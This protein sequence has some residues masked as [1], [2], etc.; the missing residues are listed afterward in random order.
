MFSAFGALVCGCRSLARKK[1]EE[2]SLLGAR[3]GLNPAIQQ[4]FNS[5]PLPAVSDSIHPKKR[6]KKKSGGG[7]EGGGGVEGRISLTLLN[8]AVQQEKWARART[9]AT[10]TQLSEAKTP[11]I[12]VEDLMGESCTPPEGHPTARSRLIFTL[13]FFHVLEKWDFGPSVR[14]KSSFIRRN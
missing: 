11:R 9:A 13:L 3:R 1:K 2:V 10:F 12:W 5:H 8:K 14:G 6:K 7:G 4:P